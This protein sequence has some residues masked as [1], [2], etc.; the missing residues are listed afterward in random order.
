MAAPL[1]T[2]RPLHEGRCAWVLDIDGRLTSGESSWNTLPRPTPTPRTRLLLPGDWVTHAMVGIAAKNPRLIAQ[3]LPYALEEQLAEDIEQLRIAHGPRDVQG[4]VPARIVRRQPLDDLLARLKAEGIE[5][6]GVYSEL[7]ALP[8]AS[9]GWNT[10]TLPNL[11][12]ARG[13]DGLALAMETELLSAALGGSPHHTLNAPDGP[14]IW[15][16]RHLDERTA[17]DFLGGSGRSS[18]MLERLRP[19]RIPAA[20]AACALIL[21]GG[22]MVLETAQLNHERTT[23]QADIERLAREAAPDVKRWI[24]PLT[25]LRQMASSTG[26]PSTRQTDMLELLAKAAPALAAQPGIKLGNLRYQGNTL[27]AQLSA[28]EG[29][30]LENLLNA[31]RQQSGMQAELAEQRVEGR[32]AQARLRLKGAQG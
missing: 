21:Q 13:I 32:E 8:N 12:L 6:D 9:E 14:W 10:L 26:A 23:M 24:N 16:H 25:Q 17:I 7:D 29:T 20:I 31:L 22:L 27:D 28:S 5:P 19:W 30:A 18:D 15:L 11:V 3:A 2:L 1:L 4:R